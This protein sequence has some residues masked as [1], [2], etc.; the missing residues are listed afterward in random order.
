MSTT[1]CLCWASAVQIPGFTVTIE[2]E[3]YYISLCTS[4][5]IC[6]FCGCTT[7]TAA[8]TENYSHWW[9]N[10]WWGVS[11]PHSKIFKW[12]NDFFRTECFNPWSRLTLMSP[13][14]WGW[15]LKSSNILQSRGSEET[16]RCW[17]QE[18]KVEGKHTGLQE[19]PLRTDG[20]EAGS[21][22]IWKRENI[23]SSS[24]SCI[25]ENISCL[26]ALI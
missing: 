23:T 7:V 17:Q 15:Q 18:K 11:I 9:M 5:Y 3:M 4:I 25:P 16:R 6:D 8:I 22:R 24:S 12:Q 2:T 13:D 1:I 14:P 26:K 21:A 10:N 19:F 20:A